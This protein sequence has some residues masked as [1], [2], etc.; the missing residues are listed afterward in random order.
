MDF[1]TVRKNLDEGLYSK[2]EE[3]EV[4]VLL[5][6]SNAMQYNAPDTIYFRQARSI[7]EL[8][9]RDFE[10]LRQVSD[11]GEPRPKVVRRGRPPNKNLKKPPVRPPLERLAPELASDATLATG[12]DNSIEST[13]YNLR[14]GSMSYRFQSTNALVKDFHRSR[15]NETCTDWLSEWND[16]FPASILKAEA[17]YG[18]KQSSL[19]ENRRATYEHF[20]PSAFGHEPSVLTTLDGDMKQLLGVGLHL[21]HGYARSL[22]RFTGNLGPA[23]WKIASKKIERVLPTGLK[24]GPGWVGEDEPLPQ[25]LSLSS[26]KQKSS[27]NSAN[28]GHPSRPITPSTSC[29]NPVVTYGTS[30]RCKEDM[31]EAVKGLNSQSELAVLK[32]GVGGSTPG[33]SFQTWQKPVL[34][35]DK[36]GFNGVFGYGLSS[37]MGMVRQAIMPTG[38]PGLEEASVPSQMLGMVGRGNTTSVPPMATNHIISEE[39]KFPGGSKSAHSGNLAPDSCLDSRAAPEAGISGKQSWQGLSLQHRQYPLPVPPDLNVIFQAPGSPSS[40]F[41]IGSPQQ[42]DLALQL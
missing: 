41:Q 1:G 17:K 2:L 34:H 28:D 40:S 13:S 39:P 18:R 14:R 12:G 37:Q 42:P 20:H 31:V 22:A 26:E 11:D 24:F 23:V 16:E 38:Q 27:N 15:N 35:P 25:P 4:D 36:N 33:P 19:D 5:I 10:N 30:L 21:D 29:L 8:A 6:C 3:F 32:S 9:K 7:Q